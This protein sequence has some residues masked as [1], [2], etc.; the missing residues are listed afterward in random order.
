MHLGLIDRPFVPHKLISAQYSP[1]PLSVFQMASRLKILMSSVSKKWTQI[2]YPF[3][4]KM[5]H[6]ANTL[7]VHQWGP[8]GDTCLQG[9]FTYLLIYLFISKTISK[10][11][12][13]IFPKIGALWK[14]TPIPEPYLTHL[15][16]YPVK[17]PSLPFPLMDPPRREMNNQLM[18][19]KEKQELFTLRITHNAPLQCT[20]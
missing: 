1:V 6:Q 10:E 12:P 20:F 3:L 17:E 18:T 9:I 7:Q 15:S 13:A 14:L 19:Y 5:S 16:G 2:Y 8:Y 11:R 4:S